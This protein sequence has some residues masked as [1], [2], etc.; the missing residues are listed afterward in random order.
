MREAAEQSV[1]ICREGCLVEPK[2]GD[3][4]KVLLHAGLL[5][6]FFP[7]VFEIISVQLSGQVQRIALLWMMDLFVEPSAFALETLN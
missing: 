1:A 2:C 5:A 6:Q 7:P 3:L 4:I